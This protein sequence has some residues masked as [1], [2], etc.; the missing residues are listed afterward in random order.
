MFLGFRWRWPHSI[1][2]IYLCRL[3]ARY[4]E[5]IPSDRNDRDSLIHHGIVEVGRVLKI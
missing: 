1:G 3:L 4:H 5:A 2:G